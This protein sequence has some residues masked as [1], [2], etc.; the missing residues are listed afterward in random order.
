MPNPY[1]ELATKAA[2]DPTLLTAMQQ[3]PVRELERQADAFSIP[4]NVVYR[5]VVTIIGLALLA[6]LIIAAKLHKD[7]PEFIVAIDPARSGRSLDSLHRH[8]EP[9]P[10]DERRETKCAISGCSTTGR[11]RYV[12]STALMRAPNRHAFPPSKRLT[13]AFEHRSTVSD[14]PTR[15]SLVNWLPFQ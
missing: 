7:I 5:L 4:D 14:F 13:L 9:K 6:S 2:N 10:P 8:R 11:R 15:W 1:R 12:R 3:D